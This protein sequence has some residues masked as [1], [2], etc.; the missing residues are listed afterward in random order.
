MPEPISQATEIGSTN[1][2]ETESRSE[3]DSHVNM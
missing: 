3:L 1:A 2:V